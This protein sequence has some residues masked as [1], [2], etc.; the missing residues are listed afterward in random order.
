MKIR[1]IIAGILV[2]TSFVSCTI[3]EEIDLSTPGKGQYRVYTDMSQGL[4]MM[5][6]MGGGAMPDSLKGKVV[7][8][9]MSLASQIDSLDLSLTEEEKAYYKN[10]TM[11][12]VMNMEENKL[13]M[14]MKYPVKDIQ[15]LKKFFKVSHLVDSVSKAKKKQQEPGE[16]GAVAPGIEG[17]GSMFSG[18]Q[19]KGS[20]YIIT[21]SSI[22]RIALTTEGLAESFGE[23]MKG[24]EMFMGQMIMTITIKLPR[25][26]KE[27][28]GNMVR[29]LE[30]KRTVVYSG[31]F[32]EMKDDPAKT[33]FYIKF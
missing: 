10:G 1:N 12:M 3:N 16:E 27:I 22:Q 28:K 31:S 19:S 8:T 9:T 13:N 20:P 6:G 24:A 30:D 23:E 33:E 29:L 2:V 25:P 18:L 21:D 11:H 14:E 4:E 32:A 15:G 7:D 26:A 17:I 5:K